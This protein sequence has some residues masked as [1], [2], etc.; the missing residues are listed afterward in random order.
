[1]SELTKAHEGTP[2]PRPTPLSRPFWDGCNEGELRVQR[3]EDCGTHVFIPNFVC[4]SCFSESL[5]W[6][7]S[8]GKGT[9]YSWT[10]VHRPQRPSF[11]CPYAVAIVELE[12]GY[13]MLSNLLGVDPEAVAVGMPVEVEFVK[14]SDDI[15]LPYFKPV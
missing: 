14:S 6:V 7:V 12:E 15:T 9:V 1:M 8:S 10:V 4:T 3:C 11:R 13:H 5:E 2:L